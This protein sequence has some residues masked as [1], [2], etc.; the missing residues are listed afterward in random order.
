M[1]NEGFRPDW[2]LFA[3]RTPGNGN[4]FPMRDIIMLVEEGEEVMVGEKEG[5]ESDTTE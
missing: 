4:V 2:N 1:L 3:L 5:E